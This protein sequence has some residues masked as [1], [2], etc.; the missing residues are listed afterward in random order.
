VFAAGLPKAVALRTLDLD[1]RL[2][3]V[4]LLSGGF[5]VGPT[6][7]LIRSFGRE[8]PVC[9]L[10]VVAGANEKLRREAESLSKTI[11]T[12]L[13]VYGFVSNI[14]VMM[15]A[16][17][18]VITKPGGLTTSEVLAKAKP[19]VIIDPIPGQEQRNCEH[20]LEAGAAA[21]LFDVE[22]AYY[23]V[24]QLLADRSKLAQMSRNARRL[25]RPRAAADIVADILK[26]VSSSALD[27]AEGP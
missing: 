21:R 25:G 10:L 3:A 23:K 4:L 11:R 2:P 19:L 26:R 15:D 24:R 20:V 18:L 16:C 17:D 27:R 5:G 6:I 1:D 13:H 14:H 22:D 8:E 9:R 12:P 7:E